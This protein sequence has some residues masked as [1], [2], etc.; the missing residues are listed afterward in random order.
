MLDQGQIVTVIIG[1]A[2]SICFS[3]CALVGFAPCFAAC[4]CDS[5]VHG[6]II[7]GKYRHYIFSHQNIS[8]AVFD[9]S[10]KGV[11]SSI[12]GIS[13]NTR[14][15]SLCQLIEEGAG[16]NSDGFVCIGNAYSSEQVQRTK[17]NAVLC[18]L[19]GIHDIT[20]RERTAAEQGRG[21]RVQNDVISKNTGLLV[22]FTALA[23]DLTGNCLRKL[24]RGSGSLNLQRSLIGKTRNNVVVLEEAV[25]QFGAVMDSNRAGSSVQNIRSFRNRDL[26]QAGSAVVIN[27]GMNK[28][29][30]YGYT[31]RVLHKR[32]TVCDLVGD[33]HF[34]VES[35]TLIHNDRPWNGIF[36][37]LQSNGAGVSGNAGITAIFFDQIGGI[38]PISKLIRS[39]LIF[40]HAAVG[41]YQQ[42]MVRKGNIGST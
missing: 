28:N 42:C 21:I 12:V 35:L 34:T 41:V 31:D 39:G 25:G 27:I 22:V 30:I 29:T 40:V 8:G 38:V 9:L 18:K 23:N 26:K 17:I 16:F 13:T 19:T 33:H 36:A 14:R 4:Q 3:L 15:S 2:A 1:G 24:R 11:G 37:R 20:H 5:V 32:H 10:D 7:G 6:N